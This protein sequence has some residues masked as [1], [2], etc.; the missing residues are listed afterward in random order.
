MRPSEYFR[1]Q[2]RVSSFSYELPGAPHPPDRRPLH[3]L[4]GLS[5]LRGH[6]RHRSPTTR[7]GACPVGPDD[8]PGFFHDNVALLLESRMQSASRVSAGCSSSG[9]QRALEPQ[10]RLDALRDPPACRRCARSRRRSA[11]RRRRSAAR[12]SRVAAPCGFVTIVRHGRAVAVERDVD[13]R[14]SGAASPGTR[15][16]PSRASRAP[17]GTDRP[18]RPGSTSSRRARRR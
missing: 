5:A 6:E 13:V 11:R 3:V 14:P 4:L 10:R 8:A 12:P 1:R 17:R 9:G 18:C 16:S 7:G 2:V 15:S